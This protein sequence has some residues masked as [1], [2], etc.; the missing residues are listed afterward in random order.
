M[1]RA[2]RIAPRTSTTIDDT[3]PVTGTAIAAL[4]IQQNFQRIKSAIEALETA[5]G[6]GGGTVT[7]VGTG[8]GLQGGPITASGTI[9]MTNTGVTVGSYQG[10]T[11]DLQGRVTNATNMG[12]ALASALT[13]LEARVS[14]LEGGTG[15]VAPTITSATGAMSREE[16]TSFSYT[17]TA[18]GSPT[19]ALNATV[20]PAGSGLTW[21]SPNLT[22]T[23][24]AFPAGPFTINLSAS[25]GELPNATGSITLTIT[26]ATAPPVGW[27]VTATIPSSQVNM[28]DFTIPLTS[29]TG[30]NPAYLADF[31]SPPNYLYD[32][33][34]AAALPIRLFAKFGAL[35]EVEV[36]FDNWAGT[37]NLSNR[38]DTWG[39]D[40]GPPAS[41]YVTGG[42]TSGNNIALRLVKA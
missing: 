40:P 22:G 13:A 16:S 6:G 1:A 23:L 10:L 30:W 21:S 26:Q 33:P 27:E 14:L 41:I 7:S 25:N 8:T 24:P 39:F 18:T 38:L 12:Y 34:N 17:L 3:I 32:T 37:G 2:P 11:I 19:P 5:P 42:N 4:P 29:F 35:A 28:V 20:T 9:S 36:D 15:N 31:G